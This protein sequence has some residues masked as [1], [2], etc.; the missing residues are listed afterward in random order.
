[1]RSFSSISDRFLRIFL[2]AI[3]SLDH[4]RGLIREIRATGGGV[5][6]QMG[7]TGVACLVI[8]HVF[9]KATWLNPER[10][11]SPA[12]FKSSPHSGGTPALGRRPK[13]EPPLVNT[14]ASARR[15]SRTTYGLH[16]PQRTSQ[17]CAII[18]H[19]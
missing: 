2:I 10:M 19:T 1:M 9:T 16:T 6:N 3:P 8:E 18:S 7:R 11:P 14:K 17:A 15:P 4:C 12:P 13:V 5:S